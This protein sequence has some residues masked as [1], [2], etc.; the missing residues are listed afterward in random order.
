MHTYYSPWIR[1]CIQCNDVGWAVR[2][3][4]RQRRL[5][6]DRPRRRILQD[7]VETRLREV[8]IERNICCARFPDGQQRDQ[9]LDR[10]LDA[11]RDEIAAADSG[12]TQVRS[13]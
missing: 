12:L 13:E 7:Q 3:A 11:D 5:S 9:H 4:L 6:D 1:E 2:E 8:W 10:P